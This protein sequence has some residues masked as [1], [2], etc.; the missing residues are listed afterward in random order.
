[1]FYR[2]NLDLRTISARID[3]RGE[4]MVGSLV[5]AAALLVAA[6]GAAKLVGP[7][8]AAVMLRRGWP[9]LRHSIGLA[10][11]VRV[12]GLT[13]LV[14]ALA[15]IGVGGRIP[16]AVLAGCYAV[17]ALVA[18]RVARLGQQA[19][20]GCF[21]RTE[22]PVGTA[23]IVL[24]VICVAVCLAGILRPAGPLG[25]LFADHSM[26]GLVGL[27]QAVLLAYLG[28]LSIT[29]LPALAADRRRMST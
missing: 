24:N 16:V 28:F 1:V 13:E 26:Q 6:A 27:A 4:R 17:F 25:G 20:C 11:V 3:E 15:V 2:R 22:S 7:E 23:H 21:G 14:I 5:L 29:A 8:P 12:A 9:A 19:S 10:S 18:V